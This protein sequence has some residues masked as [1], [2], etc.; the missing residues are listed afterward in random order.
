MSKNLK[1]LI[2]IFLIC[3]SSSKVTI[4]ADNLAGLLPDTPKGWIKS[5]RPEIYNRQNLFD[6]IDGG[7]EEY[8]VYDFQKLVV[9]KYIPETQDSLGENSIT[10]EIWK[11]NSSADAYGVF[12]LDQ[13]GEKSNIGQMGAYYDGLLRFW[14]DAFFI[15]IL[16]AE[17]DS[18]DIIWK[19]G[20]QIEKKIKKEGKPPQLVSMIP[21]DS[22]IP[23]SV[24]Y[25]HKQITLN[26]LY[27]FSDQ[28]ILNLSMET[29]C[30][31]ADFQFSNDKLR[32]L[33]IQYPD[34][35]KARIVEKNL[36]SIY[37]EKESFQ[38]NKIF[39]T[40]EKKLVGV[41][42]TRNH[43]TLVFEGINAKNILSLLN[44]VKSSL[45]RKTKPQSQ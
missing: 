27:Y 20:S 14:K 36:K 38:E 11:M 37:S 44:S 33:L 2:F 5:E 4:S 42:L 35:T 7:A 16:K 12:S 30:A 26:N 22:L 15:R 1:T 21:S 28:N 18:K 10:V 29:N 31:L 41:D 24:Y 45:D 40:K 43:L 25:F 19:L 17:G 6:Y 34:T 3:L 8:L 9:Q 32:L 23:G 13:E 39:E